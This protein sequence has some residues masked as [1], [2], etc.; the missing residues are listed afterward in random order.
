MEFFLDA[1]ISE[2]HWEERIFKVFEAGGE[3]NQ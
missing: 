1:I 2:T 3:K